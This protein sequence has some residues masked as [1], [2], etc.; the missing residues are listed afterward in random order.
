MVH[1][2]RITVLGLILGITCLPIAVPAAN[3]D[4]VQSPDFQGRCAALAGQLASLQA[5]SAT[6]VEVPGAARSVENNV[7]RAQAKTGLLA[8]SLGS[9]IEEQQARLR[10]A[11][12]AETIVF[13]SVDQKDLL[14]TG[15]S[16]PSLA[17]LSEGET[18]PAEIPPD[19]RQLMG[20]PETAEAENVPAQPVKEGADVTS[21]DLEDGQVEIPVLEEAPAPPPPAPR[22][23]NSPEVKQS[24][25]TL[26]S[27]LQDI[28]G[29]EL[30]AASADQANTPTVAAAPAP[31]VQPLQDVARPKRDLG[32]DPL[33]QLVNIDF[34]DTDL[35]HVVAILALKADINIVAGADLR[36]TVTAN[37]QQVPLR[38]AI[39]TALRMNGLGM[40]EEDGIYF[41]VPYEEAASA[42]RKTSMVKLENAKSD[43][44]KRVLDDMIQGIRDEA[45]VTVSANKTSNV[46]VISAPKNRIDELIAMAHQMDVAEPILPTVTEAISLN[47]SEPSEMEPVVKG[48]L[49]S[50]VG[51]V[52]SDKRARLLVITDVPVVVEQVKQLITQLDIPTR[53]VLIETMVVDALLSDEA[54]TGVQW[55]LNSLHRMSRRE[56]ALGEDGRSIGNIQ[57]LSLA[58]DMEVLQ[59][60]G[61]VLAYSILT[62]KIDWTG[63]IQAEIRN[64]N[65]RLVSNPVLLTLENEPADISIAQEIPY[66]ELSQTNLG[67]SQTSTRFKE[68]GTVLTVTPRVTHDKTIICNLEAKESLINGTFEGVPIEDKRE[69]SST[70]SLS[71]GQ[72]IFIGGL[73][74]SDNESSI[75][76]MPIL[77]DVPVLNFLFKSN[78]RKEQVNELLVFLTCSVID[79]NKHELTP[80]QQEV[81]ETAPPVVPRVDAWETTMHDTVHPE[82]TKQIQMRWRR[83]S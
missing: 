33:D 7:P 70:M 45:L 22:V 55:L 11:E 25:V 42:N 71:D 44:V 82:D 15:A 46:V 36:G 19:V 50:G 14:L 1:Q 67:G 72:T 80:H 27:Q 23:Q 66:I 28:K 59:D 16:G 56:A 81:L 64:R 39:E 32:V 37:L 41:I 58:A 38:L 79:N 52:S 73:R 2:L 5:S 75:K 76:K 31:P 77:G 12:G 61:S 68:I 51:Q 60:P 10:S 40:V 29:A 53:Q 6:A 21:S 65:G 54:D 48:M 47:Y 43:E 24:N 57:D 83:G 20:L 3:A 17:A 8:A 4:T 26:V 74:K 78:E 30:A 13:R 35:T 69:I 63:L 49:T 9:L 18:P 34:R 62:D